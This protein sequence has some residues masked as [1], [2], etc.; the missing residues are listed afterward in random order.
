MKIFFYL[1]GFSFLLPGCRSKETQS[2]QTPSH[3]LYKE[4]HRPQ[5][6]F[7]PREK[8]MNDPNG[9]LYHKGEYHLFYQ[10]FPDS[11]VWGPMH[12]GHAISRD[13]VHW[14]HQP[15]AIYPD[16]LGLIFSGSAV[17]DVQNTSGFGS[18]ENPPLVAIYTY[19]SMEKERAGRTDYQTQG[20]AYSLDDGR[21]WKKYENNPILKNPGIKDFRDPKVFWHEGTKQWIMILAVADHTELYN[22]PDLKSWNKLSDFGKDYGAHGGVWE[23]PDLIELTVENSSEK[24]WVMLVSIN[25]GGPNGG[26]ATQYFVG[27]FDGKN[28]TTKQEKS[29]SF[30]IDH[31]PDNYA[32][33]TWSN[34]PGGRKIFT[35]W[36]N[37]WVYAQVVPTERWRGALTS[38]RDLTLLKNNSG[39]FIKSKLSPELKNLY[40]ESDGDLNNVGNAVIEGSAAPQDLSIELSNSKNEKILIGYDLKSNQYYIDRSQ[41]GNTAFSPNF[42]GTCY[43]PRI[44]SGKISF[45]LLKD[46][47]SVEVFFDDGLSVMTALFFAS[48]PFDKVIFNS[49][50]GEAK[51]DSLKVTDLKSIW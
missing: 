39:Y 23:C 19:H 50:A 37:N 15:I 21:T 6:H 31:G 41:S 32:G 5:I 27:D 38:S 43:A 46:V 22:S 25:P 49:P 33:V 28:F 40:G 44:A 13:L 47:S 30:W 26:S 4:P 16:S 10:Y 9:M 7:S 3:P 45:V 42:K 48:Q 24:K 14:E 2:V 29:N 20:L 34:A 51:I 17:A 36:M 18:K 35:G 11:T 1:I 8:W 12:W